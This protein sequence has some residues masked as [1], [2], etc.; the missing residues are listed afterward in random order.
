MF[1]GTPNECEINVPIYPAITPVLKS[2]VHSHNNACPLPIFSQDDLKTLYE[3]YILGKTDS[4]FSL[5]VVT[6]SDTYLM[7]IDDVSALTI[8]YTKYFSENGSSDADNLARKYNSYKI[9]RANTPEENEKRFLKFLK[10]E[11]VGVKLLKANNDLSGYSMIMLNRDNN[12]VSVPC[13]Q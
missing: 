12:R 4:V 2:Y 3:L 9:N 13:P 1:P 5:G 6:N 7:V 11:G 10:D 8:F